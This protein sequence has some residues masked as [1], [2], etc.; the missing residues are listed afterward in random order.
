MS[1]QDY[2]DRLRNRD[3]ELIRN[4]Y[5]E[6]K[7]SF[8]FFLRG[9]ATIDLESIE[10]IYND[11]W[12]DLF[13]N[14]NKDKNFKLVSSFKTYLFS[15]GK[16]KIIDLARKK[17]ISI[18]IKHEESNKDVDIEEQGEMEEIEEVELIC[19][20]VLEKIIGICKKILKYFYWDNLKYNDIIKR[21]P[22][23]S[24]INS[25]KTKKYKCQERYQMLVTEA[26][27]NNDFIFNPNTGKWSKN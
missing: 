18:E 25:L 15:I 24:N 1:D 22:G 19:R 5:Y 9:I 12:I 21:L 16:Y 26:L 13:R 11:S 23:F 4:L 2:I 17:G 27:L 20:N 7:D 3:P 10:E 8:K 6:F 14:I